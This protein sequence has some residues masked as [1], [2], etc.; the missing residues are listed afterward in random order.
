MMTLEKTIDVAAGRNVHFDVTLPE[1][2]QII[3][4][5]APVAT[6]ESGRGG[7]FP[8]RERVLEPE[9]LAAI[10]D[11]EEMTARRMTHPEEFMAEM[12][13]FRGCLDPSD[14]DGMSAVDYVRKIRDEWGD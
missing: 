1:A 12:E 4:R 7:P 13:S 9:L 3:I 5:P 8:V 2:V 6:P 14:F 11:G 10:K